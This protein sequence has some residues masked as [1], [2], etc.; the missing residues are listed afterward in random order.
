MTKTRNTGHQAILQI[1]A[2]AASYGVVRTTDKTGRTRYEI[3]CGFC[4]K[5]DSMFHSSINHIEQI[6]THFTKRNWIFNYHESPLCST[7]C[8]RSAKQA[9]RDE[10][11]EEEMTNKHHITEATITGG[12]SVTVVP[13]VVASKI[14]ESNAKISRRVITLLNEHFDTDKRLYSLGWS[15]ERIR[16]EADASLDFVIKTRRDAYAELAENPEV[17]N[18]REDIKALED[19]MSQSHSELTKKLDEL[20]ARMDR[21]IGTYN[22]AQG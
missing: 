16:Q 19:L 9:K 10:R 15:D 3:M 14:I 21:L 13:P 17:S 4:S 20:K 8:M 6:M 7:Q 1:E 2:E 5:R 12:H 11:K 22:K 18:L